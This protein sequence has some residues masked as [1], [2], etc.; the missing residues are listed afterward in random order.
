MAPDVVIE[1]LLSS[2]NKMWFCRLLAGKVMVLESLLK[3]RVIPV[4]LLLSVRKAS[5]NLAW[6]LLDRPLHILVIHCLVLPTG[7]HS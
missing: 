3:V 4:V 5:W 6:C 1:V 7:T 2:S